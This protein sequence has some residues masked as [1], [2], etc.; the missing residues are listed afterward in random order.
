MHGLTVEV[1]PVY[2]VV[3]NDR[4]LRNDLL[5]RILNAVADEMDTLGPAR[6]DASQARLADVL[7][8]VRTPSLLG[9]RRIVIV[10][11]ADPFITAHRKVLEAYCSAPS[12]SG[13]LIL[14]CNSLPKNTRLYR[15]ISDGG[16]VIVCDAPKGRAV[17]E[18]IVNRAATKYDKRIGRIA[19]QMLRDHLGDSPGGLD[20]ELAKLSAFA[21]ERREITPGDINDLTGCHREEKVFAVTDAM[22]ARDTAAA[23]RH[24]E[25]V[26][27]TDRAAPGR[28]IAGLAW[29]LRRL[30]QARRDWENGT[31][32]RELARRMYTD[33]NVLQR[34]LERV[35][36]EQLEAQQ[37]DLL[38]ADIAVKTG[39]STVDLAVEKFIVTHSAGDTVARQRG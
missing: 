24:W 31:S 5:E 2:A 18:W 7:D 33:P 10:D 12:D 1:H 19:V 26:L 25:Q 32:L 4:F 8:E 11:D 22:S 28:A 14:L 35:T 39:G 17:N 21:G 34:R 37:R 29:G 30:L 16:A 20:V 6:F 27:E 15:I 23:L 13:S 36:S 3:G 38:A 9:N